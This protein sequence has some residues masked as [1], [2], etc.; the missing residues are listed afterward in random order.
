MGSCKQW[1][2]QSACTLSGC[3]AQQIRMSTSSPQWS[4]CLRT[5]TS[6]WAHLCSL[7]GQESCFGL[8][9]F[10]WLAWCCKSSSDASYQ[11]HV[12]YKPSSL[13]VHSVCFLSKF[14]KKF[15]NGTRRGRQEMQLGTPNRA[16]RNEKGLLPMAK[17]MRSA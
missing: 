13:D 1:Q 16:V 8:K 6:E 3:W 11:S 7:G 5:G 12:F 9:G 14:R 15:Y 10:C 2:R 17:G 4:T